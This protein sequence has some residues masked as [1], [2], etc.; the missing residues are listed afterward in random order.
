MVAVVSRRRFHLRRSFHAPY[1]A[2]TWSAYGQ[3]PAMYG[4]HSG[5]RMRGLVLARRVLSPALNWIG[6]GRVVEEAPR[7]QAGAALPL[8]LL[9]GCIRRHEPSIIKRARQNWVKTHQVNRLSFT[10]CVFDTT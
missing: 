9:P 7:P 1:L 8:R 5:A 6:A 2:L 3:G 4:T 10:R